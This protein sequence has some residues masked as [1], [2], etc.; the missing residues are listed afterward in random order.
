MSTA[1]LDTRT[2]RPYQRG[3]ALGVTLSGSGRTASGLYVEQDERA[4]PQTVL[5]VCLHP[6]DDAN[7]DPDAPHSGDVV[8]YEEGALERVVSAS[9][10]VFD[11]LPLRRIVTVLPQGDTADGQDTQA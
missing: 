8:T 3:V 1:P 11:A 10:E 5:L 7:P 6:A 4:M 9:G 2:W